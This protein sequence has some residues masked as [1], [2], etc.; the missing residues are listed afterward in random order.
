MKSLK[1]MVTSVLMFALVLASIVP[2]TSVT[3]QAT[4]YATV[5]TSGYF[6]IKNVKSGKYLNV[7]GSSSKNAANINIYQKDN[8]TGEMYS[9]TKE[10]K[11]WYTITPSCATG[12]RVNVYG[13][14]SKNGSN[15]TTYTASGN[16]T[17][18]WYFEKVSNGYVI[19]SA[20]NTKYV[21]TAN[22]TSNSSN[23]SLATYSS[24][25]QYQIWKLE[26]YEPSIS[27]SKSS[28]S[29]E[30][31]N[32]YTLTATIKP[33][34][35][36]ITWSTSNSS[37]ATVS[38]GKVTAKSKGRAVITAKMFGKTATCKVEVTGTDNSSTTT[39]TTDQIDKI[40]S[41][42]GYATNKYWTYKSGTTSSTSYK[43][44]NYGTNVSGYYGYSFDGGVQCCGFARFVG[45]KLTGSKQKSNSSKWTTYK[46]A[47]AVK[48]AGGLKVGDIVYSS[49][50]GGRT[51]WAIVYS[52]SGSKV[53][54]AQCLG[55]SSNK[56]SIGKGF[57][58][59]T[60]G[61]WIN[62]TTIDS[63]EKYSNSIVVYRYKG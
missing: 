49:Y 18:G 15:I 40:L 44:S 23:V 56:I 24:G 46:S 53:T 59:N 50:N 47:A 57:P 51:H 52:V 10:S 42:Y 43:A 7:A 48:N 54:F 34:K 36:T 5:S 8:T 29:I 55:S 4:S 63:I 20:N 17:Q 25:N 32:T 13:T 21:L 22:G 14:S 1:T 27:L 11:G 37:V 31:G 58:L 12:R 39:Y 16:N 2:T 28:I 19:R 38:G 30:K 9:I 26:S 61:S 41:T 35:G 3:V 62:Y 6:I 45:Y 60:T 33:T